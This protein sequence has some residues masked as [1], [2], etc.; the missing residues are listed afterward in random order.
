MGTEVDVNKKHL[1][2]L[3]KDLYRPKGAPVSEA[4]DGIGGETVVH[5]LAFCQG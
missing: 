5:S 1:S 4:V 3:G 2:D